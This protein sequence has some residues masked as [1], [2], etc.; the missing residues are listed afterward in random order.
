MNSKPWNSCSTDEL[1]R[2]L[3]MV[4]MTQAGDK[5]TLVHRCSLYEKCTAHNL[6]CADQNPCLLKIS[7]LR[8]EVSAAGL[9]PI[10]T[11]DELLTS[12]VDHL[13]KLS[14]VNYET[15]KRDPSETKAKEKLDAVAIAR[16][17]LSLAE[18]DNFE[19]ILN[20]AGEAQIDRHTPITTMRKAYLKLSVLIHP[21]KLG[22][23]FDRATQAFQALVKA[24][25]YLSTP[26]IMEDEGP[27]VDSSARQTAK[28]PQFLV[29]SNEGCYRTKVCCPRCKEPWSEGTLDGNPA[30]F[31]N[32]LMTGLQQFTCSTCLFEFGCVTAIHMCPFCDECFE[33]SPK[34]RKYI[35]IYVICGTCILCNPKQ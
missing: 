3:K 9:S 13:I 6:I 15:E 34:A 35:A 27:R 18:D 12:L 2:F 17:I 31:Y 28:K 30:Y 16:R 10:G 14:E 33:Y 8:K 26:D 29:R 5:G 25:E 1:K 7:R 20:C 22:R 23:L 11:Q 19:E 21:D 24:F 32:F 4:G